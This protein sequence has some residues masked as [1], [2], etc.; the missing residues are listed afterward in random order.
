MKPAMN[1]RMTA[2]STLLFVFAAFLLAAP[3][4]AQEKRFLVRYDHG[5][6]NLAPWAGL[7][8]Y[9]GKERV[10]VLAGNDPIHDIPVVNITSVTHELRS[11]FDP[12]KTTERVFNDTIGACSNI[13]DCAVLGPAGVVGAAGV[14]VAS[15]FT[16]K[17]FVIT[18]NWQ[19]NGQPRELAM[20]IAWYQKDFILRAFR[21]LTGHT[22][23]ERLPGRQAPVNR[24]PATLPG[25]QVSS[26]LS[27]SPQVHPAAA[28]LSVPTIHETA[29]SE[30][31]DDS[32]NL[33]RRFEIILDRSARLNDTILPPGLYLVLVQERMNGKV[34]VVFLDNSVQNSPATT[35]LA[36]AI[37]D[38]AAAPEVTSIQ[39]VFVVEGDAVRLSEIRLPGRSL[40]FGN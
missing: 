13:A 18:V 37:A 31:A 26:M 2:K 5:S 28:P 14:G 7:K 25:P 21:N 32:P 9:V 8:L 17:E 40:K 38:L 33:I 1:K 11:P 3:A 29:Q 27:P 6:A 15:L 36:K 10:R 34:M 16:P 20:K 39:T 23:T 19:E 30:Q 4:A 12:A 22:P 24:S 35:I